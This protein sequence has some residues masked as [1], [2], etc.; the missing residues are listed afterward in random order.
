MQIRELAVL[1]AYALDLVPHGDARGRFTEWFRAD[2][3]AEAIGPGF[4]IAQANHSVSAR[5]ALRGVH[6]ASV[7]PGQAK[8]VYCPAGTVLDVVVDLRVGSPTFGV[9]DTVLLDGEQPRAVYLAE[10]LGHAFVSLADASSVTYLVSTG[11]S[12]G[13]EFGV[14]P[15]DPELDLPWPADV[16]FELSAKDLAAPTLAAARD[17]GLL[18]TMAQCRARYAEVRAS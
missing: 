18:P 4:R 1:D 6:F 14:H 13:R 11:Y 5:G 9:H 12:P 7:P 17:Q 16:E 10:G 15:M 3:L 8:Y 2:V